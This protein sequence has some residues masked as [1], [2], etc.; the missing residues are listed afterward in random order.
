MLYFPVA[1]GVCVYLNP[2]THAEVIDREVYIP[3][4][5]KISFLQAK[6]QK[7]KSKWKK[8]SVKCFADSTYSICFI[9]RFEFQLVRPKIKFSSTYFGE[10]VIKLKKIKQF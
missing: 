10:V 1:H 4:G 5:F 8:T 7:A 3:S 2:S 9:S 6:A